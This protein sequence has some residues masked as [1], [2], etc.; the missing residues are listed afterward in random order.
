MDLEDLNK[1][2]FALEAEFHNQSETQQSTQ[3][4]ILSFPNVD[5]VNFQA[6]TSPIDTAQIKRPTKS[7]EHRGEIN[8]KMNE[9]KMTQYLPQNITQN[10][11]N[12]MPSFTRNNNTNYVNNPQQQ[13]N[14]QQNKL[15]NIQPNTQPNIQPSSQI[16]NNYYSQ[17]FDTLQNKKQEQYQNLQFQQA[18]QYPTQ[19]Q[20]QYPTQNSS[21]GMPKNGSENYNTHNNG[22]NLLNVRN[23]YSMGQMEQTPNRINDN[24]YIKTVD[25]KMDYRQNMNNKLDGFIFDN[26][27][28]TGFN[29][30]LQNSNNNYN[31]SNENQGQQKDT[32]MVIQDSSKDYYRQSANERMSNYSP[33]SR[34]SNIPIGMASMSVNDFYSNMGNSNGN[35]N[36]GNNVFSN[37]FG[38]GTNNILSNEYESSKNKKE[39]LNNRMNEYTPL[40]KTIQIQQPSQQNNQTNNQSNQANQQTQNFHNTTSLKPVPQL[41]RPTGS[42]PIGWGDGNT[43][44][45]GINGKLRNAVF[46]DLPIIS[47]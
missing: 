46:N 31:N 44:V 37:G 16:F 21:F 33:M 4:Q 1:Q 42:N 36:D 38:N 5:T 15:P 25:K 8:D 30:V 43:G 26:P 14:Q 17:N 29:P 20:Q 22:V 45:N 10:P 28:A 6:I 23:M 13:Q 24:G 9:I 35:S 2:M 39:I 11:P 32:R 34:A 3:Q 12:T 18:Q 7:G 47:N 41:Q 19:P 40:A 27:I